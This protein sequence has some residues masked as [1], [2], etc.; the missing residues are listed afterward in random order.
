M[1][2]I[3]SE[4]HKF[5]ELQARSAGTPYRDILT[6]MERLAN[7]LEDEFDFS[8]YNDII[9][10]L[11]KKSELRLSIGDVGEILLLLSTYWIYGERL[12]EQLTHV[13]S[14]IVA[15]NVEYRLSVLAAQGSD[16]SQ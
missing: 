7:E 4:H 1:K 6:F 11:E 5:L 12:L 2:L 10:E 16:V 14:K 15:E 8:A 13:E 9:L 3:P